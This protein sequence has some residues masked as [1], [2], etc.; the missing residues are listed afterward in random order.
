MPETEKNILIISYSLLARDGRVLRQLKFLEKIKNLSITIAGFGDCSFSASSIHYVRMPYSPTFLQKLRA[1]CHLK[2]SNF[3]TFDPSF[4]AAGFLKKHSFKK[5]YD[6]IIANEVET[7]PL[8][9][10]LKTEN[11]T[12]FLDAHEYYPL[13]FE[14]NWRFRF[15]FQKYMHYLCKRYLNKIDAMTTVSDGLVEAYR[16]NYNVHSALI[17]NAP[18]YEDLEPTKVD[19]RSIRLVY[20]GGIN[21]SR[22]LDLMLELIDKLDDRF[23][24][25]LMLVPTSPQYYQRLVEQAK[26]NGRIKFIGS[27]P[28]EKIARTINKYDIGIYMLAPVNFN[29]KNALP[30]KLLEFVQARL[31]VAIWPTPG[32]A[33]LVAKEKCGLISQDY[34]V[35]SLAG[36]INQLD[37][38]SIVKLKYNSGVAARKLSAEYN[39][40]KFLQI[41]IKLLKL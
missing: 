37:Q 9:F 4:G 36:L 20:H 7:L 3:E 14:D 6:L 15:F 23:T 22:N 17:T 13:Q 19:P 26:G 27:V 8:S 1:A 16:G 31:A 30:N 21:K 5:K 18:F 25:D 2:L 34:T 29:H 24:L 33:S 39:Q 38:E 11:T 12:I 32:M 35:D 28:P 40:E 41:V 10:E